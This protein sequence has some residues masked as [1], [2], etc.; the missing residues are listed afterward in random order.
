MLNAMHARHITLRS[1]S[2]SFRSDQFI[3]SSSLIDRRD[4]WSWWLV[5]KC[6]KFIANATIVRT[7]RVLKNWWRKRRKWRRWLLQTWREF[8]NVKDIWHLIWWNDCF[9]KAWKSFKKFEFE[10]RCEWIIKTIQICEDIASFRMMKER[11]F[12]QISKHACDVH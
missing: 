9:L 12:R 1:F 6:V 4:T 5:R 11:F 2:V 10:S 3:I 8:L 7:Y